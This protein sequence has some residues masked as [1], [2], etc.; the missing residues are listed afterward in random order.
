MSQL[1][2]PTEPVVSSLVVT[3]VAI[4]GIVAMLFVATRVQFGYETGAEA[5]T[6][7]TPGHSPEVQ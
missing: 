5:V 6:T 1:E 2:S 3:T 7:Q 4:W